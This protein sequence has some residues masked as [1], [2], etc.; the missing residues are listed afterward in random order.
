MM[1]YANTSATQVEDLDGEIQCDLFF[2]SDANSAVAMTPPG[3]PVTVSLG[4]INNEERTME[5]TIGEATLITADGKS[6]EL[7]RGSVVAV[8]GGGK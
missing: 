1:L 3:K 6:I 8:I 2:Q 4:I 5:A 7:T